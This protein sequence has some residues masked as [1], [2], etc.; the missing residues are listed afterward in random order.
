MKRLFKLFKRLFV[1]KCQ[2]IGCYGQEDKHSDDCEYMISEF[3]YY[4]VHKNGD[5]E[6]VME[7]DS[8]LYPDNHWTNIERE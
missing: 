6:P 2:C 1:K 7:D 3:G 8:G 4:I 5:L